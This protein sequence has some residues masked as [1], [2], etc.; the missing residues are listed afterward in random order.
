MCRL[1]GLTA[2]DQPVSARFWLL[3]AP[4][5][6]E[7]QGRRNPDG[8]G[9]GYF[10]A[11]GRPVVDKE[12]EPAYSDVRFIS[13]ARQ[14]RST[15]FVAHVRVSTGSVV[16]PENTHP[17]EAD[18]R[19]LA[20]NGGF[21]E[22]DRLDAELGDD[23]ERVVGDTDSE[24]LLALITKRTRAAGGDVAAGIAG[25]AG[26]IAEHVP[27]FSLNLVLVTSHELWALRYPEHHRL[28]VLD[29]RPSNPEQ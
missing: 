20:H 13:D 4:D 16:S 28:F 24:R 14:V 26:W 8:T 2:G 6:L 17:F 25:A 10:D 3:D 18:G 29:R 15:T 1:F 22:L 19:I 7:L 27:M 5:S 11:H 12:P 9:L 21:E 23:A